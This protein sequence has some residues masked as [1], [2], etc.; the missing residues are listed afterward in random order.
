MVL[1]MLNWG[2]LEDYVFLCNS[3]SFN[4]LFGHK[5]LTG[6][7]LQFESISDYI[8]NVVRSGWGGK[9]LK[10]FFWYY[11]QSLYLFSFILSVSKGIIGAPIMVH[12]KWIQLISI[13]R[14]VQSL[15]S[16]SGLGIQNC[17]EL[18]CSS[19]TWLRSWV[20]VAVV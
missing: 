8:I 1:W 14:R 16:L 13:R 4:S 19:Q 2:F 17:R 11:I 12:W 6:L 18:W 20:T 15:A 10:T 3:M 5:T 9:V 7:S